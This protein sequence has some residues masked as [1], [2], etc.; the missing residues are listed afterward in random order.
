M[1]GEPLASWNDTPA[2][3]AI[4]AFVERVTTEGGPD[5]VPPA[6][7]IAT[8]DNDGTLWCEKPL[9]VQLGFTL[10]RLAAMAELDRHRLLAPQR[11][12]VV[13]DRDALGRRNVIRATLGGHAL[14][15]GD[16]GPS[17]RGVRPGGEADRI[18]RHGRLMQRK[19]KW[20]MDVSTDW[21]WRAAGR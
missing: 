6:E 4:L 5:F 9:P 2:R 21:G 1:P 20:A 16:D 8:F 7:R 12:V 18:C 10:E 14:H 11:P 13:E 19:P 15:E 17:R 3:A